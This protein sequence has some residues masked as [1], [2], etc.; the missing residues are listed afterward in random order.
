MSQALQES[1]TK[2]CCSSRANCATVRGFKH[3][4]VFCLHRLKNERIKNAP[5]RPVIWPT[6]RTVECRSV[7]TSSDALSGEIESVRRKCEVEQCSPCRCIYWGKKI[8]E[9]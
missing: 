1:A 7:L 3:S 9:R 2:L 6:C 5:I 4:G 8:T